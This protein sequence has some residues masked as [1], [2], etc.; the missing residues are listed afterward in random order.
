MDKHNKTSANLSQRGLHDYLISR[1]S[2]SQAERNERFATLIQ[3]LKE[4]KQHFYCRK[5]MSPMDREVLVQDEY[6]GTSRRML[7][8][9]S[10]NYL[11][12]ANHPYIQEKVHK[13]INKYGVGIGGPPILNGYSCLM[14]ELEERLADFK[15][16]ESALVF[17]TGSAANLGLIQGLTQSGDRVIFDAF[18]HA[19]FIDALRLARVSTQR[20]GHNN[21]TELENRLRATEEKAND[22]FVGVEGVY[23]MDGDLAPLPEIVALC[24]KYDAHC[25]L[26][27]AHGTGVLGEKGSG[28][29]EHFDVSQDIDISMGT[30]SKTFA[31]TGGFLA[32][33]YEAINFL[34]YFARSH[35]FS[36]ALPPMTL[37]A[38]LAGLDL[39]EKEPELRRRL[40]AN[41]A[42]A[43]DQLKQFGFAASSGGAIIALRIPKWMDIRKATYKIHN[44]GIFLNPIEYPAVPFG[45]ERFRISLTAQHTKEDIDRL[46]ACIEEV[47]QDQACAK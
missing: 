12:L 39:I 5:I 14:Q 41:V 24:K 40:M 6:S 27:D 9:A 2:L 35:M 26:D 42:Y 32:G 28:T 44:M 4:N 13:A 36:A 23:S 15:H 1:E 34:R 3:H 20:F 38:V 16:Q 10:N 11:G 21:L 31:V 18:H 8:F 45:K 22:V 46:A 47:W 43:R 33:S 19:S 25:W 17:S 7:M 37:A 30:F 29:A